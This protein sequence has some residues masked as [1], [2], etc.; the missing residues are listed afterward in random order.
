MPLNSVVGGIPILSPVICWLLG[1]IGNSRNS[2]HV[3]QAKFH[4]YQQAEW[5][6][7]FHR[8]GLT[9]EV[10]GEQRLRMACRRQVDRN[11]VGIRI[12]RGVEIDRRLYASPFCLR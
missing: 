11:K 9:A 4:G 6:S 3:L 8:E 7:V 2:L 12:P 10:C 5:C 1:G